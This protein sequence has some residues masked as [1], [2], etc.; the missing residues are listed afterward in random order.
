MRHSRGPSKRKNKAKDALEPE[1]LIIDKIRRAAHDCDERAVRV[2]RD[3][4]K[5]VENARLRL[6]RC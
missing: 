4:L 1:V 3:A 2:W 5:A 6:G